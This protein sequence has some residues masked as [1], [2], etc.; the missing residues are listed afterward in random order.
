MSDRL[1]NVVVV[2]GGFAGTGAAKAIAEKLNTST[3]RLTFIT[4]RS[5][6]IL[7]PA[8]IR[9]AVTP[10]G[11]LERHAIL[12]YGDFLKGKGEIKVGK[13]TGFTSEEGGKGGGVVAL[14]SGE[15]IE[16][17]VLVLATGNHWSG[18]F[19]FPDE[20]KEVVDNLK[21]WRAKFRKANDIVLVG[22]GVVAIGMLRI[23]S[24]KNWPHNLT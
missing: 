13:M 22:G 24:Y 12:P 16:Y 2:G 4:P 18:P 19:A 6:F 14:E 15:H 11:E 21:S 8:M 20:I 1:P 9:A 7:W 3:H 10:E 23:F 5:S 17:S